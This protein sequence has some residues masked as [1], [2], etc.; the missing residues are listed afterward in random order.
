MGVCKDRG[1][2]KYVIWGIT[3]RITR[4]FANMLRNGK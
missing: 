4:Y 3:G 2:D 1:Y